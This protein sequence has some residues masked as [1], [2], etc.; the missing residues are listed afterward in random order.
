[1]G[2]EVNVEFLKAKQT[3][4]DFL[5][6]NKDGEI[7]ANEKEAIEIFQNAVV[8]AYGK[9]EINN[10]TFN[11]A[12]GLYKSTPAATTEVVAEEETAE[13]V[14]ET[15]KKNDKKEFVDE[16]ANERAERYVFRQMDDL[17]ANA[18]TR[19]QLVALLEDKIGSQNN[20][21]RYIELKDAVKAVLELMPEKYTTIKDVERQ[22]KQIVEKLES[23]GLKD[24]LHLDILK[25]LEKFAK[26]EVKLAAQ[27]RVGDLYAATEKVEEGKPSKTQE[28]RMDEVKDE[29]ETKKQYKDEIKDAYKNL[30]DGTI[31]K[32]ARVM[33]EDA[34]KKVKDL[35]DRKDVAEKA[36]EILM[37][38]GQWD[39]YTEE[40]LSQKSFNHTITGKDS[41]GRNVAKTQAIG[42]NVEAK[43]TQT[44][45]QVL[46]KLGNKNEV[47]EA[48]VSSGL[49][50]VDGD[51]VD[52]SILSDIIGLQ[53]GADNVLNRHAQID[54]AISEKFRLNSALA[55]KS[56]LESMSESEAKKLAELT[57]YKIEGKDVRK[58]LIS[59]IDGL[60]GGMALGAAAAA[61]NERQ[62]VLVKGDIVNHELNLELKG[63]FAKDALGK[64]PAGVKITETG[65]GLVINIAQVIT[66]PDRL[67]VLSKMIGPTALKTGLMGAAIGALKGLEDRGE[68]PVTVTNFTET[69]FE[70][71]IE[72]MQWELKRLGRAELIDGF[73]C[74]AASFLNDDGSWDKAGYLAKLNEIGGDGGKINIAEAPKNCQAQNVEETKGD[75]VKIKEETDEIT[76]EKLTDEKVVTV[77][78]TWTPD[79]T[80]QGVVATFYPEAVKK[81]GMKPV[82]DAFRKAQGISFT[83][84]IPVGRTSHIDVLE[85]K[86]EK[87]APKTDDY[88]KRLAGNLTDDTY[89]WNS[90]YFNKNWHIKT[91]GTSTPTSKERKDKIELGYKATRHSDGAT[92]TNKNQRAAQD[93][94]KPEAK[95]NT[96]IKVK[97]VD[98]DGTVRE[99]E[100]DKK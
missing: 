19:A 16:H 50:S 63:D 58:I 95:E 8:E 79:K 91:K 4:A 29:L 66:Q 41:Y 46:D 76:T 98:A 84:G 3:Y 87:F 74:L 25:K 71:Y 55:M 33:V 80:W 32:Q 83:S 35:T 49:I 73:T 12:M 68:E 88:E 86:G 6:G 22:H 21:E 56:K 24:D 92:S 93:A 18:T 44:K 7:Q 75:A 99:Y 38:N 15:E 14:A 96:K 59:A 28:Q 5:K 82:V 72:R 20:D 62:S 60:L 65:T 94:L 9:G 1:M 97:V 27:K 57:G 40:A 89:G 11:E 70:D 67:V 23:A 45:E 53:V 17:A 78:L 100:I 2:N 31:K 81:Y 64:L 54:K 37:A 77:P 47:Y 42:N 39:K 90:K 30:E 51:K 34:I 61:L 43:K 52:L 69:K 85:V 10:E 48:L 13:E 26:V 36:K